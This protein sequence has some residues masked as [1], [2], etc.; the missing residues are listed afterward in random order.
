MAAARSESVAVGPSI[1][2]T[3][4]THHGRNQYPVVVD[5]IDVF[6]FSEELKAKTW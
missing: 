3:M 4:K 6:D 5:P 1:W 2:V